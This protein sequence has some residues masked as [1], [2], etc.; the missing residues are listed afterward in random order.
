MELT[1]EETR[2]MKQFA[3]LVRQE[4]REACA[5]L[6]E[7]KNTYQGEDAWAAGYKAA[8]EDLALMIRR[9]KAG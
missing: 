8:C 3:E 6:V 4:E 9:R 7:A 1:V 2:V 5:A